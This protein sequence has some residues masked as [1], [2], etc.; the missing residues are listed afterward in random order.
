MNKT[1]RQATKACVNELNRVITFI[2]KEEWNE[3][4]YE[5]YQNYVENIKDDIEILY[6]EEQ[7][8]FDNLPESLQYS[9]NGEIMEECINCY[10]EAIEYLENAID[11]INDTEVKAAVSTIE[12]A[13]NSLEGIF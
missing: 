4:L 11:Y 7:E 13:I 9:Y 1:R 8:A 12:D 3:D 2:N 5:E 10:E 6:D